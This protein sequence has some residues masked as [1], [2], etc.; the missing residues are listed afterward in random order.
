MPRKPVTSGI[1]RHQQILEAALAVFAEQG[2]E[3]ATNKEI[4]ERAGVNQGLIY[5]Y[6]ESKA[7]VFF[8]TCEHHASLVTAQ[9]DTAFEQASDE[10]PVTDLHELLRQIVAVLDTPRAISLLRIMH[11]VA[12]SRPPDGAL[13]NKDKRRSVAMLAQHLMTRLREYFEVQTAR[14]KLRP[15]TKPALTAL[16]I[17]RTLI[18]S[19]GARAHTHPIQ[20]S[21]EEL[22]EGIAALFCYGLLPRG[23]P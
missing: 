17:A 5:F 14:G 8:A 6:F 9:L 1:D 21:H 20:P 19:I 15:V 12:S 13:S 16:L 7:D 3:A 10:D 4:A 18:S 2:F 22:A 23:E 11:Q